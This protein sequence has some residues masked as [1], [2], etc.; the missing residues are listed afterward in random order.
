MTEYNLYGNNVYISNEKGLKVSLDPKNSSLS[1][2]YPCT[3]PSECAPYKISLPRGIYFLEV[4]GA[5]GGDYNNYKKSGEG[6]YSSGTLRIYQKTEIYVFVGG[7]G[8]MTSSS[9]ADF[10]KS[11]SGGYNGGGSSKY[12]SDSMYGTGGGASD[13]RI[14]SDS[15]LSRVIVA[16]GGAGFGEY[17]GEKMNGGSCVNTGGY[18]GGLLGGAGTNICPESGNS[19]SGGSTKYNNRTCTV[20]SCWAGGGGGWENGDWG[21]GTGATG[22][23]GSGFV[24]D[25]FENTPNDYKLDRRF[26]IKN[27]KTLDK[28]T[29]FVS[30]TGYFEYGHRGNGHAKITILS[31]IVCSVNSFVNLKS[32]IIFFIFISYNK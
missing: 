26:F 8:E 24:F 4:W 17:H 32:K 27:G 12:F 13:I 21:R 11:M 2:E 31:N 23:G 30:P 5:S 1:F 25:S 7:E 19:G 18:G 6:G 14:L 16:G 15:P 28:T 20:A 9:T 22:G 3:S 10:T 29:G